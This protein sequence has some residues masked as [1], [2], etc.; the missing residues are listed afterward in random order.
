MKI[1]EP[2]FIPSGNNRTHLNLH[3]NI[4]G[5]YRPRAVAQASP[6]GTERRLE[7]LGLPKYKISGDV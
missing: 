2:F 5:Y 1:G 6:W 4:A 3:R 7:A